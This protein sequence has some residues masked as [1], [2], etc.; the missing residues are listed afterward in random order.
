MS[1]RSAQG[2]GDKF[3]GL[4]DDDEERFGKPDPVVKATAAQLAGRK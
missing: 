2:Q 1:K 4:P 3:G